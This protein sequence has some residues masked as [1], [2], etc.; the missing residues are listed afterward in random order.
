M[1][2][3]VVS[4]DG[5]FQTTI[6]VT[7]RT[8]VPVGPGG[9]S[10]QGVLTGGNG[11]DGTQAQSNTYEF[12]VPAGQNELQVGVGLANDPNDQLIGYLVDPNGQTIGYSTNDT[13]DSSMNP[14]A[15]GNLNLYALDPAPG[16][17]AAR[18]WFQRPWC[19]VTRS[20]QP[21]SGE[22]STSAGRCTCIAGGL[23]DNAPPG[24]DRRPVLRPINVTVPQHRGVAGDVLP[25]P[26]LPGA[27]RYAPLPDM[28]GSTQNINLPVNG[29]NLPRATSCRR[30]R[31]VPGAGDLQP[32]RRR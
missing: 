19:R 17:V 21:F 23:P 10:F 9:G 24:A 7:V 31:Q 20:P 25:D 4:G 1:E 27:P 15:T 18:R 8:L 29:F 2:S 26:R 5:G 13:T 14:I 28:S 22:R 16:R 6:P 12:N 30:S 32:G 11:R 3:V